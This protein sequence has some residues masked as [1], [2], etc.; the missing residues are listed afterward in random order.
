LALFGFVSHQPQ[1]RPILVNF[2]RD[3][4]CVHLPLWEIGFVF[5]QY[6]SISP[7]YFGFRPSCIEFPASGWA[8]ALFG[9]VF[10][11][12]LEPIYAH[13]PV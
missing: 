6:C 10:F 4:T 2:C 9:F 8:L 11:G 7:N 3:F 12:L 1:D 13:N 5:A